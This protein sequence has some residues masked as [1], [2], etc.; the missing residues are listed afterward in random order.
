MVLVEAM[1]YGVPV[2]AGQASGAVPWVT[3]DGGLLVT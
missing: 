2:V 1:A 3:A